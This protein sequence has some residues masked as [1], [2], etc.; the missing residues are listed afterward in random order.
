KIATRDGMGSGLKA[1]GEKDERVV[2]LSA[3]LTESTRMNLFADAFPERF[4]QV[5]VAEQNLVTVAS[6]LAAAGKIPYAA[7]YAAFM[8]GR[9]WEQIRTT[10]CYNNQPVKL[11]VAHAGLQTRPDGATHQMLEDLALMRVLPNMI[12]LYPCDV[13]EAH[14]DAMVA[15]EVNKTVYIL[16][17]RDTSPVVT[18]PDSPFEIGKAS[19]WHHGER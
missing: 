9:C 2:G 5:G 1:I 15:A 19:V 16:V 11:I 6:G 18:A 13:H 7:S 4:I 12:V 17:Q 8:P 10:I 14:N 3:D